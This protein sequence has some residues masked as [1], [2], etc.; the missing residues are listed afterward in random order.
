MMNTYELDKL[1]LYYEGIDDLYS[2][3]QDE[4]DC[5]MVLDQILFGNVLISLHTITLDIFGNVLLYL[6]HNETTYTTI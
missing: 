6:L 4:I 2:L 5:L 3:T 1:V